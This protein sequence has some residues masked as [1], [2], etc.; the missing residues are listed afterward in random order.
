MTV[1]GRIVTIDGPSGVGKSTVSRIV[2]ADLGYTYLDTGAM[3]RGVG[4]YFHALD[5]SVEDEKEIEKRLSA[6]KLTLVPASSAEEDVGVILNGEDVSSQIRTAEI[7]MIASNI[8]ALSC[9][10]DFL[11]KM[12]REIGRA[13]DIVA[14]GRDMGTVVFPQAGH[15]FFLDA[16]PQERCRRRVNQLRQKGV[17][18]DEKE[19]LDAIMERDKNDRE[20]EIAPL[21][22]ADDAI[23]VD[24]TDITIKDVCRF[25]LNK[26]KGGI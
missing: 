6:I 20:R 24:T 4:L 16:S 17:M 3:Y 2:A 5:I 1:S 25:I 14:E 12:Q 8:S 21:R 13:G 7:S 23:F 15:K 22:R 10:R 18:A 11:T 19:T 26:I 9:V